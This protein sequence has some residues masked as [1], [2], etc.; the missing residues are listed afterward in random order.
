M[1]KKTIKICITGAAG[2]LAYSF[3]P[4]LASGQVFGENIMLELRLL[5]L[6][7]QMKFLQGTKMDLEDG[8][9]PNLG[10]VE[11]GTSPKELFE[12]VDYAIFLGGQSRKPGMDRKDLLA[13][14]AEI[15]KK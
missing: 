4:M 11:I 10:K 9:F 6:K 5:D 13:V 15:F 1:E 7:E 12:D 8:L 3:L 14:N 2:N